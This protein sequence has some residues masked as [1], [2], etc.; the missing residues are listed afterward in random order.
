MSVPKDI[1]QQYKF[2]WIPKVL[3]PNSFPLLSE[4]F[5]VHYVLISSNQRENIDNFPVCKTALLSSWMQREHS[6]ISCFGSMLL[7]ISGVSCS[8]SQQIWFLPIKK[9]KK[10]KKWKSYQFL[11]DLVNHCNIFSVL[12]HKISTSCFMF[13]GSK[14]GILNM[15]MLIQILS[16]M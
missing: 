8:G 7:S 9:K 3:C 16:E 15:I 12:H 4:C 6:S 1:F 11:L 5:T 14:V 10:K 13:L 2:W